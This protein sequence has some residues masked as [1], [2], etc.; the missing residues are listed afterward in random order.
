MEVRKS[1][2][3]GGGFRP[4]LQDTLQ[5]IA[6]TIVHPGMF[7]MG[8]DLKVGDLEGTPDWIRQYVCK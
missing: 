6:H 1:R 8:A 5:E 4:L 2:R 3:G 7:A